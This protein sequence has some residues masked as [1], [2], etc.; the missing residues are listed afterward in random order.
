MQLIS[1]IK[2]IF[3]SFVVVSF[4]LLGIQINTVYA[5]DLNFYNYSTG[6][7]ENYT[8]KQVIYTYN[9]RELPLDYPGIIIDGIALADFEA[10]FGYELGLRTE[11]NQ[12]F[13]IISDGNKELVL[14]VGSKTAMVDGSSET[15]S[16]APVKLKF[17]DTVKYYVPTRYVAEAFGFDYVWVSNISTVRLTKALPLAFG[18]NYVTY[19]GTIYSVK[20]QNNKI[21]TDMPV[22][23]YDG[24]VMAPAKQIFEAAGCTY[25]EN[26]QEFSVIK[27]EISL[28]MTLNSK[29]SYV[30]GKKVISNAL[31]IQVTDFSTGRTAAY[32]SL[33]FAADMLGFKL[34]Y[35]DVEKN[36]YID[37][38]DFT[39]KLALYPDFQKEAVQETPVWT[40]PVMA[41][42]QPAQLHFDWI[43]EE[44]SSIEQRKLSRV[45]AYASENADIVELFGITKDD[46]N[47]F[48]DNGLVVFELND[49]YFGMDT[50][51]YSDYS[52]PHLYYTLLTEVNTTTKLFFH[53]PI[54]DEWTIMEAEDGVRVYFSHA[55]KTDNNLEISSAMQNS[56]TT[57]QETVTY[58]DDKV[59]IPLPEN[60]DFSQV[61]DEDIYWENRFNI[62]LSGNHVEF[63]K[64]HTI[65]NP[66]YGIEL[67]DIHYD[68]VN[69]LTI[70]PFS[71]SYLC[72]YKYSFENGYLM[73]NLDKPGE[74]YSK[75]VVLDAGHGGNDPGAE[76]GGI[77][78]KDVNF[79]IINTYVK[80]CFK[81]SDIKVYFTRQNDVKID[82]YERAA[83]ASKIGAD[84]FISLHLNANNKSTIN[85]TEIYYSTDNNT[86]T[87]SGFNSYQLAKALSNNLC[88]ALKSKNRGVLKAEFIVSKYN[89]VPAALIEL[90]YMTNKTELEKLT[91][92]EY[93]KKAAETIYQT[94]ARLFELYY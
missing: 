32:V 83:F 25:E 15:M 88:L 91:D 16:V 77:K 18:E 29:I 54:E 23:Y 67:S 61:S 7:Y 78:E 80:E 52:A 75:I 44:N 64:E 30:N 5:A 85:G 74:V 48:F 69:N 87:A 1:K 43:A 46:I 66:Y 34:S 10:L 40:K 6:F 49:I 76:K 8:G 31:P 21:I 55:D 93:Q 38:T 4:F 71:S 33:E 53:I 79:K 3:I 51:Y 56:D 47:D 22:V 2:K 9:N 57:L 39:G 68:I 12:D 20:Y 73:M 92:T 17:D 35:S 14:T 70:I 27:D 24:N 11:R 65:I 41:E 62:I 82:L 37:E 60:I 59:I 90:G 94:V 28:S 72:G 58:P 63:Y 13:L 26:A 84:M 42:E 89:T 19:N 86:E 36:Y 45:R 50:L 81:D